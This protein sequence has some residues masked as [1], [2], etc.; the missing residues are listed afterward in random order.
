MVNGSWLMDQGSPART[1][2]PP[3]G[4]WVGGGGP[5]APAGLLGA[6]SHAPLIIDSRLINEFPDSKSQSFKVPK[7]IN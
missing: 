5:G 4:G 1:P 3:R 7:F 2:T 6:M